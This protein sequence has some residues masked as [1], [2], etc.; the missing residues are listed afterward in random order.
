M[1]LLSLVVLGS[2]LIS[3]T[4]TNSATQKDVKATLTEAS[5]RPLAPSFQLNDARG[6]P[7][8]L[9]D[10]RGRPVVLNLWATECGGCR[11]ELPT[12]VDLRRRY[13]EKELAVIGVSMEVMYEGLKTAAEGWARVRPFVQAHAL[14]Y[15]IL[16]DDGSV[17]KDYRVMA[18]PS[19]FVIDR[20]GRVAATY[21]GVV[22]STDLL[23]K[24]LAVVAERE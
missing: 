7:V 4:M 1:K 2:L 19:T 23:E 13:N 12:F 11:A 15:T 14:Q 24:V 8:K 3:A 18:M 22:D 9:S 10:F 17:E 5:G 16:L 6:V 21:V 20:R